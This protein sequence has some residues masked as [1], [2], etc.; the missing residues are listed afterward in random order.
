MWEECSIDDCDTSGPQ[1]HDYC[2]QNSVDTVGILTVLKDRQGYGKS[3]TSFFLPYLIL[4][5]DTI[6]NTC[7]VSLTCGIDETD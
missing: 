7:Y 1:E 3:N 6:I 2:N 4:T 5:W